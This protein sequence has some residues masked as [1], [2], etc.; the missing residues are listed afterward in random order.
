M[1]Q[2]LDRLLRKYIFVM[3]EINDGSNAFILH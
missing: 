3:H 1:S 2:Y